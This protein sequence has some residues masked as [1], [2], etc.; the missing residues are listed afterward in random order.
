[1]E[2]W[3]SA[4]CDVLLGG[5]AKGLLNLLSGEGVRNIGVFIVDVEVT[6]SS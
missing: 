1:M 4:M 5:L 6:S 2:T 3:S